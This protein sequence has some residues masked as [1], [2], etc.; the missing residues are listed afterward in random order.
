MTT[1][2]L[3]AM[4][5]LTIGCLSTAAQAQTTVRL[6]CKGQLETKRDGTPEQR[7]VAVDVAMDLTAGTID[8]D[9]FWGCLA[10]MG[11]GTAAS[12]E[13]RCLGPQKARVTDSEVV[14]FAKSDSPLY[15]AQSNVQVNRYSATFTVNSH[16]IAN[17]EAKASW[18]QIQIYGKLQCS[19]QDR[20]F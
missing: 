5:A 7:D 10:D 15:S 12:S 14:F 17:P 1:S 6:L 20:K 16:A 2:Y 19:S 18:T 8:I 3:H 9:G 11:K 13:Y 4:L